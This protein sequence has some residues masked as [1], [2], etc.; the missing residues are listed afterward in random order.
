MSREQGR[1]SGGVISAGNWGD[2]TLDWILRLVGSYELTI[3]GTLLCSNN[4]GA[5]V[6]FWL[7]V[8]Q[9]TTVPLAA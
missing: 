9:I 6:V 8:V 3:R 5:T 4:D 2:E 7:L 1:K